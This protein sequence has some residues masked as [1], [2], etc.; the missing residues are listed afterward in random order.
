MEV[1]RDIFASRYYKLYAGDEALFTL[2]SPSPE[3]SLCGAGASGLCISPNGTVRPCIGLN[4]PLGIWP[5]N[6]LLEIWHSSPFFAEFGAIRLRDVPE[7]GECP[8]FVYCSRC[9]GAWHAEHG[10]FRKPTTFACKL[11]HVWAE[12]Q[13]GLPAS[14]KGDQFS[15]TDRQS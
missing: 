15:E 1:L 13:R 6:R 7:C 3:A 14:R 8:D 12:T 10:D 11:A 5:Q 2:T 9:P 4:I